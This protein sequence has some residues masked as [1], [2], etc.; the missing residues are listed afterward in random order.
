VQERAALAARG[1]KM[2]EAW[3]FFGCRT[4]EVRDRESSF[5]LGLEVRSGVSTTGGGRG[6]VVHTDGG[7]VGNRQDDYL[8]R[9]ELEQWHAQGA[10]SELHVAFSREGRDKVYV[11]HLLKQRGKQVRQTENAE[12]V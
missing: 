3:L 6:R 9:E 2:G 12:R 8:Y 11:Q 7:W 1:V 4:A 10:L 5:P